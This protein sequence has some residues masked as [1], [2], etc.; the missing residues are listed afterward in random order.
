MPA[1]ASLNS[2]HG[3][4]PVGSNRHQSHQSISPGPRIAQPDDCLDQGSVRIWCRWDEPC[5]ESVSLE[6][7]ARG[8]CGLG[9]ACW[10]DHHEI[11]GFRPM[12][13][14]VVSAWGPSNGLGSGRHRDTATRPGSTRSRR[15]GREGRRMD[16]RPVNTVDALGMLE[17]RRSVHVSSLS[18]GAL[19]SGAVSLGSF[20]ADRF[21]PDSGAGDSL[22]GRRLGRWAD[23]RGSL[24]E[25]RYPPLSPR[26]LP[27]EPS[28]GWQMPVA[29][30]RNLAL[31]WVN[32]G[33][34]AIV[35]DL[36]RPTPV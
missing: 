30:V 25:D 5:A 7:K 6:A 24:E 32:A 11:Y 1:P 8:R 34:Q 35:P 16:S 3:S 17:H 9:D 20:S 21:D 2:P 29:F 14:S 33:Q 12:P 27:T 36:S 4:F 26:E 31:T 18:I 19:S 10:A 13:P 23:R 28:T 22:H 15:V